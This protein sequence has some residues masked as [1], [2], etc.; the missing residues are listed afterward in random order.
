ME[1]IALTALTEK[2]FLLGEKIAAEYKNISLYSTK[3][4]KGWDGSYSDF[5]SLVK[6][7]F[8]TYQALI[9]IMATGIVVRKIAPLLESKG[10]DPA[11][12]VMDEKGK[13]VISLLSG[14][15]GGAN[16]LTLELAEFLEANPVITTATDVNDL[17]AIDSFA[18]DFGL[19][20]RPLE[21]IK[22]FNKKLLD[23]E[24][25]LIVLDEAIKFDKDPSW[26][27]FKFIDLSDFKE[28]SPKERLD[29]G[30]SLD[31]FV[32]ISHQEEPEIKAS[33]C[34]RP[35][36]III[37][38]GCRKDYS[39]QTHEKNFLI[40]LK[41]ENISLDAIKEIR[42]ITLKKDEACLLDF[43]K[44]YKI[45]LKIF[46]A[47]QINQVYED[48]PTLKK[49]DFVYK[50]V[51]AYG[52]AEAVILIDQNEDFKNLSPRREM[53]GMTLAAGKIPWQGGKRNDS[54]LRRNH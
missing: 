2:G 34:L 30:D 31:D 22:L 19:L 4:R 42:T 24:E 39:S 18:K 3:E 50:N 43:S 45:P 54:P 47:D 12:L 20:P 27:N 41:E 46:S 37:G 8:T 10:S 40:F 28:K 38:T 48:N 49:S 17:Y 16:K 35:K 33:L 26:E 25:I 52:V 36:N 7:L 44:K 23:K 13:N 51:G 32:F 53:Q 9:F 5:T 29:A 14:H 6:H 11:I 21:K 1:K 15:L